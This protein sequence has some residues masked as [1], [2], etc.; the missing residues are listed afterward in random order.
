MAS[1]RSHVAK[2]IAAKDERLQLLAIAQ[3]GVE[4]GQHVLAMF[5]GAANRRRTRSKF[6]LNCATPA[7]PTGRA[8]TFPSYDLGA[9][10]A[11]ATP[12]SPRSARKRRSAF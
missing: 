9:T 2:E 5:P 10:N 8:T 12:I 4:R 1:L 11:T 7:A 3:L 6:V